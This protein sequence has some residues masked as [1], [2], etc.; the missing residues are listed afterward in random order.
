MSIEFKEVIGRLVLPLSNPRRLFPETE[1][2]GK[3]A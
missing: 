2:S 1:L 3:K